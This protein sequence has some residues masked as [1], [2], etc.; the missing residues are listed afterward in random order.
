MSWWWLENF[1]DTSTLPAPCKHVLQ[2]LCRQINP[3]TGWDKKDPDAWDPASDP[4]ALMVWYDR[5]K[6][7]LLTSY[8]QDSVSRL[9]GQL[10]PRPTRLPTRPP[11]TYY[12]VVHVEKPAHPNTAALLRIDLAALRALH[13]PRLDTLEAERETIRDAARRGIR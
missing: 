8:R 11:P 10:G 2:T 7:S 5:A 9:V 3:P 4:K 13:D 6:L 1:I 12:G